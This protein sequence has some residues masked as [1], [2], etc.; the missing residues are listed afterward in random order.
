MKKILIFLPFVLLLLFSCSSTPKGNVTDNA[1][2]SLKPKD[3]GTAKSRAVDAMNKAKSIKAE[4]AVKDDFNNAL[5]VFN[6]AEKDA[7][8]ATNVPATIDKYLQ[9]EELFLAAYASA[10][11]KKEEAQ[12][13]LNKAKEDIR[14]VEN[15]AEAFDKEQ[16]GGAAQGVPSR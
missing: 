7:A 11:V 2:D 10:R 1:L 12:R 15:N 4:V 9:S 16:S 13:Q 8:A 5:N 3:I 6:D 14:Q